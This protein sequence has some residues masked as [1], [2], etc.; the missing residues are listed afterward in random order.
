MVVAEGAAQE[1][2]VIG[3]A[4]LDRNDGDVHGGQI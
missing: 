1:L 3:L 2:G 4:V